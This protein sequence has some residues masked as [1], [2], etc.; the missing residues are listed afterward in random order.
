MNTTP[1]SLLERLRQPTPRDA[2]ARFVQLYSPLLFH[3]ARSKF[4]L[5]QQ[6]EGHD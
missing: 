4:K 3:W 2:W 1:V 5:E 6:D